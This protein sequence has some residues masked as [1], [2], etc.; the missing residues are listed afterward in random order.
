M[1]ACVYVHCVFAFMCVCMHVCVVR[2]VCMH[3]CVCMCVCACMRVCACMYV[4][5]H[6]VGRMEGGC[7][8]VPYPSP[9]GQVAM[10]C[11]EEDLRLHPLSLPRQEPARFTPHC[12][13]TFRAFGAHV[14]LRGELKGWLLCYEAPY[15]PVPE[16]HAD[17]V[18]ANLI[19]QGW[20]QRGEAEFQ[21]AHP[22]GGRGGVGTEA[23][24]GSGPS[25]ACRLSSLSIASAVLRQGGELCGF[26]QTRLRPC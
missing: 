14:R 18:I 24:C 2:C 1:H 8:Q 3:V 17:S 16:S 6:L 20:S 11:P 23:G 21:G 15:T 12:C 10:S 7:W 25:A 5:E 13:L 22:S 9:K 19:L 26:I 4:C